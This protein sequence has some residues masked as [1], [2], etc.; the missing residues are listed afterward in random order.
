MPRR[1]VIMVPS[2]AALL[3][4]NTIYPWRANHLL[5]VCREGLEDLTGGVTSE[6]FTA[7]I[8]DK[9]R[10]WINELV[11]VNKTFLFGLTQLS[12]NFKTRK[13][14][15]SAHSYSIMEIAELDDLRLLKLK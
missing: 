8:M 1:T 13:G 14:I 9:D 10:F 2:K 3:G 5:L 4:N 11:N 7:D 6:I 15:V 12:G